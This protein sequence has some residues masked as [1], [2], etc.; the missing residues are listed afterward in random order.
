M[1]E[2]KKVADEVGGGG[3]EVFCHAAG[4]LESG[5]C[6]GGERCAVSVGA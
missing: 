1:D 2:M 5:E 3:F 4:F 6:F